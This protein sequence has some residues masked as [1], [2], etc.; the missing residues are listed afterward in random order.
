[1][2]SDAIF[3]HQGI[4]PEARLRISIKKIFREGLSSK[5]VEGNHLLRR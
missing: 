2:L 1:M 3:S 4:F 5:E